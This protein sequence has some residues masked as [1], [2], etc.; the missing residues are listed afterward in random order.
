MLSRILAVLE[1][2]SQEEMRFDDERS[3]AIPRG[4]AVIDEGGGFAST[5]T[6]AAGFDSSALEP[7][8]LRGFA[9]V[10][11][12]LPSFFSAIWI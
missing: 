10:D 5:A 2:L 6:F 9:E 4:L 12:A 8:D 11:D 7:D 1:A 3:P